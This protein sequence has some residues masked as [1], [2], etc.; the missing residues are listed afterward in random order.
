MNDRAKCR[1]CGWLGDWKQAVKVFTRGTDY[2]PK[3]VIFVCPRC[4]RPVY[5]A[6]VEEARGVGVRP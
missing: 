6:T 2:N 5:Q 3:Y 1:K 4:R